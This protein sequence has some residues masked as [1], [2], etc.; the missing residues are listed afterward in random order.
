MKNVVV[1]GATGSIGKSSLEIMSTL[2]DL[3][4]ISGMTANRNKDALL[5]LSKKY[6]CRSLCLTGY[7]EDD[8]IPTE[9]SYKGIKGI[10]E[11]LEAVKPDIVI[12]GIAGSAGLL[13][14]VFVLRKGIDLALANKE[15]VVMAYPLIKAL[16]VEKG[17]RILPVDSEHSAVF[18]LINHYGKDSLD[19]IILTA[20]GGPFREYSKEK[21]KEVTFQDALKHPTWNMGPK[22]TVD[23]STLANKGLEVIEACRLF[24]LAPENVK[25]TI[26][27]QSLV[28]SLIQT[29]DG[30][31]YAQVS[32]P[33]MKH[34]I[35]TAL[36]WPAF[37]ENSLEPLKLHEFDSPLEMTF[38][39]PDFY[40]FPM[41]RLA[42]QAAEKNK[43]YTIAYNA[44][45]EIAVSAFSQGK[46]GFYG[47]SQL[48]EEVLDKDWTAEPADFDDVF[49]MDKKAREIAMETLR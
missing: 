2:P 45:N 40:R 41:L 17:S 9:I 28:H 8:Q 7:G 21:L 18:T 49:A 20:S 14:S 37:V 33:D 35:L 36:T 32:R 1:L 6:S 3:F 12:N 29:K 27:P 30:A 39:G 34:P 19:K 44:A 5:A 42:Y 22:I 38:C 31:L 10:E 24:D 15:T 4:H 47:I 11:L 23:S 13:P 16:A 46:I 43:S 25:V 26:H 48:T